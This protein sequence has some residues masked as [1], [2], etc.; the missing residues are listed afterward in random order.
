M[1]TQINPSTSTPTV[2]WQLLP[3]D[4]S[5]PDDP[6]ENIQ[7][8]LLAAALTD[9][10]DTA[11]YIQPDMLIA[12]NFA[13][14]AT[15]NNKIV[16]KAPDWF[17]VPQVQ[18]IEP[19]IIRRSYTPNIQ[20]KPVA[21]VMEFL[22]DTDCGEYSI[23]P[24]P[25]YGKFYFYEQI[26]K[27]PTYVIYDPYEV[28]LEVYSLQEGKYVAQQLTENGQFWIQELELFLGIWQGER[29][30]QNIPWLRFWNTQ[31]KMLQWSSEKAEALAAKLQE[32]GIDPD[33]IT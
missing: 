20:G 32:L 33:A 31:G 10:L 7:Q 12:S 15:V 9:A 3:N 25:P 1:V 13:L 11:G 27:V 18:P 19:G 23:R 8:P 26:L 14:V 24:T 28:R 4:Y 16:V 2:T 22:S 5:L 30:K 21:V 6:L 17:Y 29:L